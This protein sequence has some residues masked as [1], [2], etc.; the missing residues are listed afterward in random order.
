M[1]VLP[2]LPA[3]S[4][5]LAR[6]EDGLDSVEKGD[7]GRIAIAAN[8]V[9]FS[10]IQCGVVDYDEGKQGQM[11]SMNADAAARKV[12]EGSPRRMIQG[13]E[14]LCWVDVLEQSGQSSKGPLIL[15]GF[16]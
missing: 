14:R 9:G 7:L 16:V 10:T 5:A 3:W 8:Q 4:R 15:Q 2:L 11:N 1:A 12:L 6:A 13:K